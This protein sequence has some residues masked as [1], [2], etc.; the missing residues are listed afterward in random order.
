M[1]LNGG[2]HTVTAAYAQISTTDDNAYRQLTVQ[3]PN[4]SDGNGMWISFDGAVDMGYI[5]P[6][7]AWTWGPNAGTI[8]PTEIWI[9]GTA[10]ELAY[11]NGVRA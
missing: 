5:P 8:K 3:N 9:R 2:N 10:D 6:D 11:F 1:P 4:A 7:R